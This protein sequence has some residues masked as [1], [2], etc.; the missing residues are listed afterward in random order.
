MIWR[1]L[2]PVEVVMNGR[3]LQISRPQRRAVL[4]YLLLNHGYVV[5]IEQ[6]VTALWADTPP[7]GARAQVRVRVSEIRGTLRS[8]GLVDALLGIARGYRMT[9]DG[10][11]LDVTRFAAHLSR[12]RTATAAGSPMQ[13]A[14]ELRAALGLWR[15]PALAG[16]SAAFVDAAALRLQEQR[17][18]AYEQL[19]D[20]ELAA[21]RY[22]AVAELLGPVVDA[23]PLRERPVARLMAALAYS[24]QQ[25]G[26]LE[27]FATTRA[28][29]ADE[30]GVEPAAELAEVHLRVLRR[31]AP[32]SLATVPPAASR[33]QPLASRIV[34]PAQLPADIETFSGREPALRVLGGL[35]QADQ[36]LAGT[37]VI[38]AVSGA[39]GVGKTALAVHWTHRIAR[40]FPDGQL[41]VNLNGFDADRP[42]VPAADALHGF[43]H[44]LGVH[45]G[46]VPDGLPERAAL[47]RSLLN[48]R[49]VLIVLDNARDADQIRPLLPGTAGSL[50]V[51]TSRDQL[52]G[53][54]AVNGAHLLNL[55]LPTAAEARDMLASR[56]G[57]ARAAAEPAAVDEIV[58]CCARLPL[59]MA[60]VA[61]RAAAH[62]DFALATFAAELRDTADR[63]DAFGSDDP[64]ADLRTVFWASYRTLDPA[65]ARLFR[66]LALYPGPRLTLPAVTGLTGDATVDVRESLARLTQIRLL[67][68][69]A[70]GRYGLHEL[71]RTYANELSH[72][73]GPAGSGVR[74]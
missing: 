57:A 21:G 44:A 26:A 55:G 14:E 41:Y 52:L 65:A 50:M 23:H 8:A 12:A 38:C 11:Q 73:L 36:E 13:A 67:D 74:P 28:R 47:F 70:A 16:A 45:A 68:E 4:A 60:V 31:Q 43:L 29:L 1:L 27:L 35:L 39:A 19:A 40:R 37:A 46:R 59:A 71:L 20:A 22:E 56:L 7:P 34:T 64:T 58:G 72:A 63:L 48:G 15:G 25:A 6:L 54:V 51:V 18:S 33:T 10:S 30:L 42:P 53:L 9:V 24:G 3:A 66:L 17:L 49:R 61:A 69:H 2:G 62:P 32:M 5:S